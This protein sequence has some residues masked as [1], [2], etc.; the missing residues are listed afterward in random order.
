MASLMFEANDKSPNFEK[1]QLL[2]DATILNEVQL[3][4]MRAYF[5][6]ELNLRP[7]TTAVPL[8]EGDLL[9]R[10]LEAYYIG[11]KDKGVELVY[12]NELYK[13]HIDS[14]I[15]LGEQHSVTQDLSPEEVSTVIYQ[16][17]EYTDHYRMDGVIPHEVERP[18]IKKLYED[19]DLVIHLTG[20]ID[21]IAEVPN[22][23]LSVIDHK[24][25]SRTQ[26]PS[27]LSNQFT[28]YSWA[29]GIR[30]VHINK[31]GFQK[32]LSRE[33][34][35]RRYTIY[36]TEEQINRWVKNVIY[37]GQQYS[38]YLETNTWPENRTS[39]DKYAGCIYSSICE[40]GTDEAREWLIK[41]KYVVGERWDVSGVL[42]EKIPLEIKEK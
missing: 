19:E 28:N 8:E 24:K 27:S 26:A 39:C 38:F 25:A 31:V 15:S 13:S 6:H 7:P 40:A 35:F 33:E 10:M 34:R 4:G 1:K 22:F 16:F 21:L 12:N 3:C 9:H 5:G 42:K 2:F 20:K 17:Q 36:Y 37:W 14:C 23:G 18:F 41:T 30:T 29:T 32:T 11:V